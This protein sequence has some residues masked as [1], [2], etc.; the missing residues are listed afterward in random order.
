MHTKKIFTSWLFLLPIRL[1]LLAYI[2]S[3]FDIL[4]YIQHWF[5]E[6]RPI[7]QTK[8]FLS[9]H[10]S[11]STQQFLKSKFHCSIAPSYPCE[12]H[13]CGCRTAKDCWSHCC[14]FDREE[15]L[16]WANDHQFSSTELESI[17]A[18]FPPI[19]VSNN[20]LSKIKAGSSQVDQSSNSCCQHLETKSSLPFSTGSSDSKI[21][22]FRWNDR[23][24]ISTP[25]RETRFRFQVL[26]T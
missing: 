9:K 18:V 1:V 12:F 25:K 2:L 8:I 21:N 23:K 10:L 22:Q 14:C 16:V 17:S 4:L 24:S 11:D 20:N 15:H 13:Q 26:A 7:Q 5:Y 19:N 3:S 6:Y